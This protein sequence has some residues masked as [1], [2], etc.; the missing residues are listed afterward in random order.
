M[1]IVVLPQCRKEI[2]FF[3]DSVKEDLLDAISDLRSGVVLTMPISRRM[4]GLPPN[5]FELRFCDRAGIFRVIYYIKK[6]D[7][8]YLIHAFQKKS[9]KT[10]RQDIEVSLTRIKRLV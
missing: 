2:E 7:A 6:G 3:P 1:D 8:I 4:M 5:I 10:S 9:N